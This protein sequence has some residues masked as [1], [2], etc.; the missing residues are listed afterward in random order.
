[1]KQ[2]KHQAW[3]LVGKA[4]VKTVKPAGLLVLKTELKVRLI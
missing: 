3:V 1:M 4:S 2:R